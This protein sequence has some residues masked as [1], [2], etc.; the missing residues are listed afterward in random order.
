MSVVIVG[1]FIT[2][3]IA[4]CKVAPKGGETVRGLSFNTYL[5]GKGANQAVAA[6]RMGSDTIM[7]GALGDDNFGHAFIECLKKEGFDTSYIE[8]DKNSPTGISLVT[9]EE[10]GQNRI[11]M[12]PGANMTYDYKLLSK[13]ENKIK[14]ASCVVTQC[15]MTIDCV[16]ELYRLCK[17]TGT[18]Y[19][20]NPAPALKLPEEI[21]NGIYLLTPNET[22]LG[23]QVGKNPTTL[24]EFIECSKELIDKGVQNVIVTLGENGS[25]LVNKDGYKHFPPYKVKPVDT[26]GAGDS[27]TGSLSAMIDQ[28]YSLEESIKVATAVAALEIQKPGG[29][30]AMPY[31]EDVFNFIKEMGK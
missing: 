13:L 19:I 6:K 29:I 12:T 25:L 1:S 20:V 27:F 7:V 23:I 8:I 18:K 15:E 3:A 17:K 30:P 26:L 2:D 10:S 28:G 14:E 24:D 5:G 16:I 21:L 11:V 31:K 22:E 4:T 9:V